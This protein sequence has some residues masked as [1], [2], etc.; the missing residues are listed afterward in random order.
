MGGA[1]PVLILTRTVISRGP[2]PM[3]IIFGPALGL[4]VILCL[5]DWFKS[6]RVVDF[7]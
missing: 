5:K 4:Q 1:M 3:A 2:R 6:F 7:G